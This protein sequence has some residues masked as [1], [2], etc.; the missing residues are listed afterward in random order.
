MRV[1]PRRPRDGERAQTV[2]FCTFCGR[3]VVCTLI[4]AEWMCI[5]CGGFG[6]LE[7]PEWTRPRPGDGWSS[8]E[9][10]DMTGRYKSPRRPPSDRPLKTLAMSI[11]TVEK[12]VG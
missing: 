6:E 1:P 9:P 8:G 7:L 2:R 3:I 5:S 11:D 10:D 12:D 4:G